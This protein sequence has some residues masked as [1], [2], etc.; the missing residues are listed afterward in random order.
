MRTHSMAAPSPVLRARLLLSVAALASVAVG[1][2]GL[3][4]GRMT[5]APPTPSASDAPTSCVQACPVTAVDDASAAGPRAVIADV[6]VGFA[7]SREGALLAAISF[8]RAL[9]SDLLLHPDAFRA[10]VD[11]M[12]APSARDA[13]RAKAETILSTAET[14]NH[15]ITDAAA[16]LPVVVVSYPLAA[17]VT[18]Y[19][20]QAATV[21]VLFAAVVGNGES[22][23]SGEFAGGTWELA[24]TQ[25]AD[26]TADWRAIDTHATAAWTSQPVAWPKLGLTL[27]FVTDLEP[28]G[29][30]APAQP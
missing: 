22:A 25:L 27:P 29:Y 13:L 2:L 16:G 10:A 24:W 21:S 12:A 1:G 28:L 30:V 7:H 11:E 18:G 4:V 14:R 23:P 9:G 20:D 5:A 19:S 15:F 6:P 3:V 17:R 26:G 8:D